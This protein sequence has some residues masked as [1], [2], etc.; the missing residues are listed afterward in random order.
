M[1]RVGMR[2]KGARL[3]EGQGKEKGSWVLFECSSF[4]KGSLAH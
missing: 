4:Y 3:M 1:W 2:T